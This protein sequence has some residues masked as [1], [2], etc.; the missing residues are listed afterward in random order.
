MPGGKV[1]VISFDP[2]TGG[3]FFIEVPPKE[4]EGSFPPSGSD[5]GKEI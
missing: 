2:E 3:R 5:Y 4:P 1:E